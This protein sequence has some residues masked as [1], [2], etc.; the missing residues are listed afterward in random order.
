MYEA[1]SVSGP[2]GSGESKSVGCLVSVERR[3]DARKSKNNPTY[4]ELG[5]KI[6]KGRSS[7]S[8]GS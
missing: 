3:I 1:T 8:S 4:T 2:F 5:L 7:V 6:L